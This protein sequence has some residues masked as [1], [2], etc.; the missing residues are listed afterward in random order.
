MGARVDGRIGL[1]EPP[2]QHC[3]RVRASGANS[4]GKPTRDCALR[5]SGVS[6][7]GKPA[8]D[9]GHVQEA[10]A[11][12]GVEE[13][14]TAGTPSAPRLN[15]WETKH[16]LTRII[17]EHKQD[18]V[19]VRHLLSNHSTCQA[20]RGKAAGPDQL[21]P[22]GVAHHTV[23]H[24]VKGTNDWQASLTMHDSFEKGDGVE[25]IA[26]GSGR[27]KQAAIHD[28]CLAMTVELLLKSP[29]EYTLLRSSFKHD[30][31]IDEIRGFARSALSGP[32]EEAPLPLWSP[33]AQIKAPPIVHPQMAPPRPPPIQQKATPAV[34]T[35]AAQ[36]TTRNL[37]G[38][39]YCLHPPPRGDLPPVK[40]VPTSPARLP[41][42]HTY[43][44]KFTGAPP[45]GGAAHGDIDSEDLDDDDIR[46]GEVSTLRV[47]NSQPEQPA[48]QQ[49]WASLSQEADVAS[50]YGNATQAMLPGP[51]RHS[52]SSSALGVLQ[53]DKHVYAW[54]MDRSGA[55]AVRASSQQALN[56]GRADG[57]NKRQVKPSRESCI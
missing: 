20:G 23:V 35:P 16:G 3:P 52:A 26:H 25:T 4:R 40:P 6:S 28:C 53:R 30:F 49:P 5:V 12:V 13:G 17:L 19:S 1:L 9:C 24:K 15:W 47:S 18:N 2:A 22:G 14:A 32:P 39:T 55:S 50:T 44:L 33:A 7:Q 11:S 8:R 57:A 37:S 45:W 41:P 27:D 51:M 21:L 31:S 54:P 48:T 34:S 36:P 42:P 10:M 29:D 43:S 56:L 46:F 38:A